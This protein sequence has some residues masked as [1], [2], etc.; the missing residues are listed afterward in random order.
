MAN[1]R[2][3][4]KGNS[5]REGGHF[6]AMPNVVLDCP[7][8]GSLSHPAKSL[9]LEIA[10]QLN[11]KSNNNGRLLC[12]MNLL[13]TRGWTSSSV[14]NR[15]KQ[16]LI[17]KGFIFETV[18]GHRPNKA[19]WYAVTYCDINKHQSGYDSGAVNGFVKGAYKNYTIKNAS[20]S[21]SKKLVVIPTASSKELEIPSPSSSK[22]AVR[23][24]LP[25][26][27][28]SSKEHL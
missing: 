8:Y 17:V 3:S 14:V 28:S 11:V 1:G 26:P 5:G 21:S 9:F 4:K 6:L 7:S 24:L 16:D 19:S 25:P 22:G 20:L 10:K 23:P 15:A 27:P 18:K 13:K 2:G 12:S